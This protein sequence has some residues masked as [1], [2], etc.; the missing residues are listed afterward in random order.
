MNSKS[1]LIASLFSLASTQDFVAPENARAEG[2]S[3][4]CLQCKFKDSYES[5]FTHSYNYC[6]DTDTCLQDEWNYINAWCTSK[7]IPGWQINIDS[8]C[9][10]TEITESCPPIVRQ[11]EEENITSYYNLP[12]GGQCDITI[13]A[14]VAVT[15]LNFQKASQLGVLFNSYIPNQSITIPKGEIQTITVYNADENLALNFE[16]VTSVAQ[17]LMFSMVA[18][19]AL[20]TTLF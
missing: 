2:P 3:S 14:S 1:L 10:A 17:Y 19:A 15:R 13:D 7:W 4:T 6:Y 18:T 8:V 5:A 20:T 9:K 11:S 12:K 16:I